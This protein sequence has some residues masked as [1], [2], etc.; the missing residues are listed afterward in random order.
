MKWL[1]FISCLALV[2]F[3]QSKYL[4]RRA[5]DAGHHETLKHYAVIPQRDFAAVLLALYSQYAQQATFQEVRKLVDDSLELRRKCAADEHS[6]PECTKHLHEVFL[7]EICHEEGFAAKYGFTDCCAKAG[8]E[9]NACIQGHK[10][11]TPEFI[12]P[13]IKPEPEEACKNFQEHRNA[14][15]GQYIYEV[16]RRNPYSNVITVVS[17]AP[18]YGEVIEI[19]C[20][21]EDR[22]AC[23]GEK[24]RAV[25]KELKEEFRVQKIKCSILKKLGTLPVTAAKVAHISQKFPKANFATVSKIAQDVT[26]VY[27][28]ACNGDTLE[29]LL[30][31]YELADY[32]CSHKETISSK[33]DACCSGRKLHRSECLTHVEHDDKPAD[34]SERVPEFIEKEACQHY[35][36][37]K[38]IHLARFLHE[39][40]RRHPEYSHLLL[41][42][43]ARGYEGL[44][45]KCCAAEHP[46]ECLP[47]GEEQ[48]KKH[49]GET[50]AIVKGNCDQHEK[51]GDEKFHNEILYRY[52]RKAPQLSFEHLYTYTSALENIA[53]RCCSKDENQRFACAEEETSMVIGAIC[54]QHQHS[55]IN[56][57]IC[58]CCSDSYSFRVQCF[59]GLGA[60]PS[61]VPAPFA[62]EF[63]D[64][65]CTAIPGELL[66]KKQKLLVNLVKHKP[67]ITPEQLQAIGADF[68]GVLER[69]CQAEDHEACFHDEGPKLI[70]QAK[71]TLGEH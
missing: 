60:D 66:K 8:E 2:S 41:L 29:S 19:C 27:E 55:P 35:H 9:R 67:D 5:R 39:Y 44:L 22:A 28:E 53:D 48:L 21:A 37:N 57:Q 47:Q 13:F 45:E 16:A 17:A 33:I 56:A 26:H 15:L 23:F 54:E 11:D 31:K 65:L 30:D 10:N 63:H 71:A 59:V 32:V 61:Y 25:S 69:C 70:E 20:A 18:K 43:L 1:T 6:D 24:A 46:E 50:I 62:P 34:L 40:A 64:D 38:T 12:A 4:P 42:R 58:K 52:T 49:I 14:T 7:D 51:L 68:L 36:E 3:A